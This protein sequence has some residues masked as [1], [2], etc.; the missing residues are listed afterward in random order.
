MRFSLRE[1]LLLMSFAALMFG[2]A[3]QTLFRLDSQRN[4]ILSVLWPCCIAVVI[5]L[6]I[7]VFQ[8]RKIGA[9]LLSFPNP[10][11]FRWAIGILFTHPLLIGLFSAASGKK[12]ATLA[13]TFVLFVDLLWWSRIRCVSIGEKGVFGYG[14]APWNPKLLKLKSTQTGDVLVLRDRYELAVPEEYCV[15]VRKIVEEKLGGVEAVH[16][17]SP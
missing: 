3:G 17:D 11:R 2:A 4:P 15:D 16:K 1:L 5:P 6:A 13:A 9:H 12:V 7:I 14:F 10:E 8:Q